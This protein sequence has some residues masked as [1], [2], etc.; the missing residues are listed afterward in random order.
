MR[1]IALALTGTGERD[2]ADLRD[3]ITVTRRPAWSVHVVRSVG[4]V[5]RLRT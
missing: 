5:A 1:A 2:E 4:N 3:T